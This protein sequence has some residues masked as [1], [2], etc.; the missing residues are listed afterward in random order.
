MFRCFLNITAEKTPGRR[1]TG[2]H[3][4]LARRFGDRTTI[5]Q[6]AALIESSVLR[7]GEL[8]YGQHRYF[9]ICERVG[10]RLKGNLVVEAFVE[11]KLISGGR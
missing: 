2:V 6:Q 5:N 7:I 4:A 3:L 1:Y 10:T 11:T 8:A 9:G